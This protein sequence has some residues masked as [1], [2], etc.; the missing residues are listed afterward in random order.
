MKNSENYQ[1]H[2]NGQQGDWQN[3]LGAKKS[4]TSG[5]VM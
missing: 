1:A 3:L 2:R 5:N 4:I